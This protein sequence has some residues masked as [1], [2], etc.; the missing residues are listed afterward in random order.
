VSFSVVWLSCDGRVAMATAAAAPADI[1][2]AVFRDV[3]K[4]MPAFV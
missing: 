1:T 4:F 2:L 3:A